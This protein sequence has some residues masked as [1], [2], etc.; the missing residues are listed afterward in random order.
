MTHTEIPTI[1]K[2]TTPIL[3]KD[4]G[5]FSYAKAQKLL[6]KA[7][8]FRLKE[9]SKFGAI[10]WLIVNNE[11]IQFSK[12]KVTWRD[13]LFYFPVDKNELMKHGQIN[14]T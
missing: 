1:D 10:M 2:Q 9:I 7:T 8:G 14:L 11:E 13:L 12:K 3:W 5:P 6:P 4:Y